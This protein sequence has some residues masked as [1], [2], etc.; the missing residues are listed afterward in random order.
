MRVLNF[1][2]FKKVAKTR[3]GLDSGADWIREYTVILLHAVE[4]C[5]RLSLDV[6]HCVETSSLQFYFNLGNKAILEMRVASPSLTAQATSLCGS[7]FIAR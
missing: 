7:A 4:G 6:R 3:C 2:S 5:L 1:F